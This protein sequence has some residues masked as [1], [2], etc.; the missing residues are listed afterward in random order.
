[1]GGIEQKLQASAAGNRLQGLHVAGAT[2]GVD[3]N[4]PGGA[5]RNHLFHLRRIEV[6]RG[7]VDIAEYRRDFLPLE[8]V[9]RGYECERWYDHFARKTQR[10]DGDFQGDR[11]VTHG[12]AMAHAE[13]SAI[14][15][16]TAER[17]GHCSSA[18]CGPACH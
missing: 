14:C 7:W 10:A 4:D 15:P 9:G 5:R 2:P 6:V 1:M 17:T 12:D 8:R 3:A 18:S 13:K 11:S 16:R